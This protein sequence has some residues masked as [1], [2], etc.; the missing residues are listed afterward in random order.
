MTVWH[1][2]YTILIGPLELLFQAVFYC[3][4]R[5]L[6]FQSSSIFV[7]SM[8]VNVLVL[9]LYNRADAIQAEERSLEQRL[10][11]MIRHIKKTFRG[12]ERVMMLQTFYRQNHYSPL[13]ALK[14]SLPLLLEIPFFIAAYHFLSNQETLIGA[15]FG[16]I[17]DLGAPDGLLT[18]AGVTIHVLPVAMTAINFVSSAI[19]TRGHPLREKLQ[20]YGMA[21]IFL[22]LL[23][24]SP[25][26]LVFYWTLNNLF[27]LFKNIVQR[28]RKPRRTLIAVLFVIGAALVIRSAFFTRLNYRP[29]IIAELGLSTLPLLLSVVLLAAGLWRRK[30]GPFRLRSAWEGDGK[31]FFLAALLLTALTGLLIPSAVISSSPEEFVLLSRL[32]SPS[33]YV[34]N[35]FLIAAG[36]F[37]CWFD[38]FYYLA[39][40]KTRGLLGALMAFLAAAALIDYMAFGA[41][42]G[43]M[44]PD[45]SF[46]ALPWDNREKLLNLAALAVTAAAVILLWK[47]RRGLLRIALLAVTLACVGMSAFQVTKIQKAMPDIRVSAEALTRDRASFSLS[48]KGKNVVV[49]MLDRAISAYVPYML[50]EKPELAEQLDG[51][52]YYPNTIS[53][54]A[55]TIYGAPPIFGGYEYTPERMNARSDE[56]LIDK[57][58]EALHVMPRLFDEAGYEITLCDPPIA[59]YRWMSDLTVFDDMPEAHT[60]LTEYG[61]FSILPEEVLSGQLEHAWERNFF[62]FSLMRC[63]PQVLQSLL[64]DGAG[65]MDPGYAS[66]RSQTCDTLSTAAGYRQAFIYSYSFLNSLPSIT[67]EKEEG[68][69]FLMM[70]NSITHEPMLLQEPDYTPALEVD[71][72]AYDE[73]HPD[74]FTLDGRTMEVVSDDHIMHYHANMAALLQ[75]GKWFDY[76]R[77]NDLY[78]NTRIIIVADHGRHMNQF[79]DL[80]FGREKYEDVM[81]FN[82][83]LMV[84]DFGAHGFTTDDRFMTNADVPVLALEGVVDDPVNPYTGQPINSDAKNG[85]QHILYGTFY[86]P[87][88]NQGT[89]FHP[90]E[91]YSV[92]DDI[93]DV[94]NWKHIPDPL[95]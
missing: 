5:L 74:R 21:L 86:S 78:D 68:D 92:Q 52:T 84:K 1:A 33:V 50:Q 73:A 70:A 80:K 27:S 12:D 72:R 55:Y 11:P 81:Y 77:A 42:M 90:G 7:L 3:A 53:F 89:T 16:P 22:V 82:P 79:S 26:G 46:N 24:N 39:D 91:W 45:L 49:L 38:L 51:F 62:C 6:R 44:L 88:D 40:K 67:G 87:D 60:Y 61:Q 4:G 29:Q 83:L 28:S 37:L 48:K 8:V 2:L 36:T 59:G 20:L 76:L 25:S 57:H 9:P 95:S 23:Y 47:K 14:S 54:G 13:Y 75:L 30:R 69:T 31:A 71:N 18:V 32:R 65:Y 58:D 35:A 64:Y 10:D 19:Y 63:S 85:P 43:F 15:T 66:S 41:N 34:L 17:R 93:F 56:K 94:D